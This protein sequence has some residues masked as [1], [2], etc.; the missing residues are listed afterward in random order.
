[1]SERTDEP[2][3]DPDVI[4]RWRTG[5]DEE[6]HSTPIFSLR[7]REAT[8]PLD[9]ARSGRFYYI[10]S[11]DWVNVIALTPANEVVLIEQYR[12]GIDD[13][14][15]EIPGGMVDSGEDAL[16]AG[17]RELREETGYAGRDPQLIG[18]VAPNPAIL[19]N[20]CGTVLV[21][22][23]RLVTVTEFDRDEEIAVRLT[24]LVDIPRLIRE[25]A[26]VHSL[27]VAAFHHLSLR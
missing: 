1:M 6:V 20:R 12:H 25:R 15:L 9:P 5:T 2:P 16:A 22:D 11:Q 17:V 19:N 23:A 13:V 24:P 26:I 18:M 8:S 10:D 14:C 21:R 27:V 4:R 3:I 7:R